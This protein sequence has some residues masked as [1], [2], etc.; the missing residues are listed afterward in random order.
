MEIIREKNTVDADKVLECDKKWTMLFHRLKTLKP[1][2]NAIFSTLCKIGYEENDRV[3]Q[4]IE[5]AGLCVTGNKLVFNRD[6]I[7]DIKIA[8]LLYMT[9]HEIVH[10]ALLHVQ[11][12]CR[13]KYPEVYNIAAD[14]YTNALLVKE[15]G[16]VPNKKTS[17]DDI[18]VVM[19]LDK[20]IYDRSLNIDDY[21]V[22]DIY[23]MLLKYGMRMND[24]DYSNAEVGSNNN[25]IPDEE[26][27]IKKM[28]DGVL[29]EKTNE[30]INSLQDIMGEVS[31]DANGDII[32][33]VTSKEMSDEAINSLEAN[34]KVS[35]STAS[36]E[37]KLAGNSTGSLLED[38]VEKVL[39]PK[40]DW[41]KLV[42]KFLVELTSKETSY[43]RADRRTL[44]H[45]A[46]LP[47]QDTPDDF[48]LK[49]VK[50]CTDTSGSISREDLEIFYAQLA[51]LCNT[52]KVEGDLIHWD[53]E[54][55]VMGDINKPQELYKIGGVYG[56]G[57][58][59]PSCLF[60][61]FDSKQC[62][63]KPAVIIILTDGYINFNEE[64][65]W[66]SRYGKKTIWII[67]KGGNNHFEPPF[68]KLCSLA[69]AA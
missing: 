4:G 49:N 42:R 58:T 3:M 8:E 69:D 16:F 40:I 22:E 33:A 56:G 28:I 65:Q 27:V 44:Y 50:M 31:T 48:A 53:C 21:C 23:D 37:T 54:C 11:R 32:K 5:K 26:N 45:E 9:L 35:I 36:I 57:G 14:L 62:K 1:F 18:E 47:G 20:V 29:D 61:Y 6:Y 52:Y 19:P 25:I 2:Y 34:M 59:D 68:G 51:Q 15:Y 17:V 67:N 43:R 63:K 46:I 41:R 60:R 66:K 39:A 12:K 13:V 64:E 24:N 38:F 30:F 10:F 55:A 7:I